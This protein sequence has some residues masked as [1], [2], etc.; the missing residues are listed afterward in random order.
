MADSTPASKEETEKPLEKKE[1]PEVP[2]KPKAISIEE[3]IDRFAAGLKYDGFNTMKIRKVFMDKKPKFSEVCK[4]IITG[5]MIGNNQNRL[6]SSTSD[7]KVA[8]EAS[9]ILK[10]YSI[11]ENVKD[12]NSLTLPRIMAAYAPLT[13]VLRQRIKVNLQNQD[14]GTTCPVELQTPSL[15]MYSNTN[16]EYIKWLHKFAIAIKPDDET[17][18]KAVQN[19]EMY[20]LIAVENSKVDDMVAFTKTALGLSGL[21]KAYGFE[22]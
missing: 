18:E 7:E 5:C 6:T 20:R 12:S 16:N 21:K 2:G 4:I 19:A 14:F 10:N 8:K 9:K 11:D 13:M 3:E 17:D 15:A 1:K 22:D